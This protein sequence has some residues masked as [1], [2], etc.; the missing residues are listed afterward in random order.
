MIFNKVFS[1]H[2]WPCIF[3]KEFG[4]PI[5]KTPHPESEDDLRSIGL[6][7]FLSKRME[8]LL[9]NWIWKYIYPH[10]NTDQLGGLPGCSIVHYIMRMMDFILRNLDDN[11]NN[12]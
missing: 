12:E 11:S 3:K 8:K 1:S 7:P 6:T 10:I 4:V 2:E 9:I 5:E